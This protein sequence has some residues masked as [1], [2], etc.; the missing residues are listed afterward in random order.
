MFWIPVEMKEPADM[1]GKVRRNFKESGSCVKLLNI[2]KPLVLS[3][4]L[5]YSKHSING[6]HGNFIM[7]ATDSDTHSSE[8]PAIPRLFQVFWARRGIGSSGPGMVV[9]YHMGARDQI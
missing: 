9:S 4:C 5:A 6:C 2:L 3:T 8:G 7:S 1:I